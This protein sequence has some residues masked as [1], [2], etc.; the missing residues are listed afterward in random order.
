VE[1]A[2]PISLVADDELGEEVRRHAVDVLREAARHASRPVLH[3]R[4]TR[5]VHADPAVERPAVA[6]ASLDIGGRPVRAH[7]AS[8]DIVE[9]IDLLERRLR[10][11]LED[12]EELSR[13]HRHEIGIEPPGE[14][15]HGSLQT[16]RPGY[17]PR[18]PEDR[19]L[20]R[21]KTF[22]QRNSR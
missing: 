3:A 5:R 7:V 6:K 21:R 17:F 13:A 15:R 16:A 18:E 8:E 4:I 11:N 1:E 20:I 10:R 12:L 2:F 19:E 22:G 14:W 9:A